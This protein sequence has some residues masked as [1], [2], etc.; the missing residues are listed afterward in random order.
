MR[1]RLR[2]TLVASAIALVAA[3]PALA[4]NTPST[5]GISRRGPLDVVSSIL[6]TDRAV[7]MRGGWF[8]DGVSCLAFRRLNVRVLVE[9]QAPGSNTSQ[10]F[11]A[12]RSRVTQNCAEGGP[13]MGFTLG[14]R[15]LG[16]ACPNGDWKRGRYNLLTET[17]HVA[18][19]QVAI[20]TIDWTNTTAC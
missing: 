16:F 8:H 5:F 7:D 15:R 3:G 6:M 20:A 2:V 13:N 1:R 12:R 14:A 9:Y 11:R 10:R 18:T 17:R 4:L 19:G